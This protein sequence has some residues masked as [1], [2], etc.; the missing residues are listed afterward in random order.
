MS[1]SRQNPPPCE[2]HSDKLTLAVDELVPSNVDAI[3][4]GGTYNLRPLTYNPEPTNSCIPLG[5]KEPRPLSNQPLER[6]QIGLAF[7][8][9]RA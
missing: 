4:P 5:R 7:C 1:P 8:Q 3:S 6:V 9:E 2:F